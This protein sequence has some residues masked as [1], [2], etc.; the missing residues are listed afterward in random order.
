[1]KLFLKR[2]LELKYLYDVDDVAHARE[3]LRGG[4]EGVRDAEDDLGGGG[5]VLVV[6]GH[7]Y[8]FLYIFPF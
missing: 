3:A 8:E 6:V 2:N 5:G 4:A 7:I 1:M